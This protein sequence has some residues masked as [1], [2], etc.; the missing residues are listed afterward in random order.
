MERFDCTDKTDND[1]SSSPEMGNITYDQRR[2]NG[3]HDKHIRKFLSSGNSHR[4]AE[5][6]MIVLWPKI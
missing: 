5:I 2:P 6:K 1:R 4:K 3:S